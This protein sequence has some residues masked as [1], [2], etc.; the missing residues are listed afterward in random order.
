MLRKYRTL[1]LILLAYITVF[2]FYPAITAGFINLD[3]FVMV[4]EN[5]DITS[6]SF[7]NIKHVFSSF[8]Y[9]LYHP[10]VTLSYALEYRFCK[11]DP[12][13]YHVDNIFLHILNTFILFFIIK[14][15]SKSFFVPYLVAILFAVHPVHVEVVAWV[16]SRKDTLYSFFFLLSILFYMKIDDGKKTKLFYWLSVFSF[17]LSCLSKPMAVTLPVVL[18]LIDF[19]NNRLKLINIKK[20]IPFFIISA[21]FVYL[22]VFAHY[23]PEER[24]ITTIFVRYV[25]F[26]DAHCNCLF[27]IFKFF[28]PTN[29]SCLYPHFYDHHFITPVFIFYSTTLL[30][31]LIFFAVLSLKV[32]KKIFFGFAFFLITVLPSSGVMQTGVAPVA[33]RYVYIPYAGLMFIVAE[34]LYYIYKKN[35]LSK[36][37]ISCLLIIITISLFV[38]TYKRTLLWADNEKLM[39]Q[40][41]NYAPETA[42]HAYLL[43]GAIYKNEEKLDEA[44]KDFSKSFSINKQNAYT[45]FHLGHLKQKQNKNEE[46]EK[47]YSL[48]PT[49]S[50][51]YIATVNNL[52]VMYDNEN[53][54]DKA[55][56]LMQGVLAGNSF[57]IPDYFYNT[58]AVLYLKKNESDKALKYLD[59]AIKLNGSNYIYYIQKM[60]VLLKTEKFSEFEKTALLGLKNTGN[61]EKILNFLIKEYF[62]RGFYKVADS[63]SRQAI[64]LYPNNYFACFI[65]GNLF[66][67]QTDYKNALTCY[68]MAI[69]LARDNGEYYFK[70]AA[71]WYMLNNYNQAKKD[72]EKAE[73][74]N[75]VADD[76]FKKD[77][78]KIK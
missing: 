3:D 71:V 77:L 69:L 52:A 6:L 5:P 47:Y 31:L 16:T 67:M 45:V 11:L 74:Y 72:V 56:N 39:T 46:A 73:K 27:Y 22:A 41:V 13:L 10:V 48:I 9:K 54:T 20:Y 40:A 64:N 43:R 25:N 34:I 61:N 24:A 4:T 60:D 53:Q 38:L 21:I 55:I 30:Y 29:L 58:L 65:L 8:Q 66:A 75:F 7:S 51:N 2:A 23:S 33:D 26:L 59:S 1:F 35:K 68:T 50:V 12:Y 37:L 15:L 70:R 63:Y 49:S 19:Y 18:M 57:P 36:Y 42:D 62:M 44:E 28:V 32:N 76:E 17:V 78:E 14:R